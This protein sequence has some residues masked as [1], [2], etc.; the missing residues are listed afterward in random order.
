[1]NQYKVTVEKTL[2]ISY[3]IDA[4]TAEEAKEMLKKVSCVYEESAV[5]NWNVVALREIKS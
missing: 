4:N 1:M 2:N 5:T 3:V